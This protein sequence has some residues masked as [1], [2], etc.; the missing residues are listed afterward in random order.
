MRYNL[1]STLP[2]DAFSPRGG[3]GPFSRGMTLE[4]GGGGFI[5][6]TL[7][8]IAKGVTGAVKGI[9]DPIY[10]AT[11]KQIPGVDKALLGLDKFV[12]KAIPGGWGTL[13]SVASTFI[14]GSTLALAG[15]T[16]TGLATGLG[17][18]TGSGVLKKGNQFN[19]QGAIMGGAM[20]YG[21]SQLSQGLQNAGQGAAQ[22]VEEAAKANTT[23]ALAQSVPMDVNA[24]LAGTAPA[25]SIS[26]IA[27][28]LFKAAQSNIDPSLLEGM[29]REA[30]AGANVLNT[31]PPPV[32]LADIA[33]GTMSNVADA[34][35]GIKNLAGF[36]SAPGT[37]EAARTA[38]TAP[39]TQTGLAAG[40]MGTSGMMAIDEQKKAAEEALAAGSINQQ[41]YN[42][43]LAEIDR[44]YNI[45]KNTVAKNPFSTNPDRTPDMD[46]NRLYEGTSS[47]DTLYDKYRSNTLYAMG[48]EIDAEADSDTN[49]MDN[50]LGTLSRGV[51]FARGGEPRFL[52]GGGDGMSDSIR[53]S[54]EGKQEA[55]LADGE[56]VI[57]ADV[58]S[59]IGNG[60][61][62][63]GAKQLY[64][65]MDRVRQARVGN[66]KQGK[67][68]NPRKYLAA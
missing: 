29:S 30:V 40:V 2:I 53:A 55:R 68:I 42:D 47:S 11:L 59:H 63:A 1:E 44:Q 57:P 32:G 41:Q 24:G 49:Y 43:Q 10:E 35:T 52:S 61:S 33:R 26:D 45:A 17:A 51:H 64:S 56:F 60:S 58:V 31:A 65:M 23:N 8:G 21:A 66:K 46:L 50:G 48:G 20:A 7:G 36:G 67:Q 9:I 38:F 62:K 15:M 14:P 22:S 4:G 34:G 6:K 13:A 28:D 19:L 18:L 54:I 27:P 37:A 3:R 16:K 12:G 25:A 39:I 5:G